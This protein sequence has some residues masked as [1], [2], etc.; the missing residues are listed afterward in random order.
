MNKNQKLYKTLFKKGIKAKG[1]GD[2]KTTSITKP[3]GEGRGEAVIPT[4]M[5]D[6]NEEKV[7]LKRT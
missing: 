3:Q 4:T 5:E 6:P 1:G 7:D 2:K